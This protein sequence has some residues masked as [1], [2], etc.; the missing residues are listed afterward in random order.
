VRIEGRQAPRLVIVG[1][2]GW[3]NENVLDLLERCAPLQDSVIEVSGLS[4]PAL[5]RLL[6]NARGLLMPSF[7]EGYGLPVAEALAA[8]VPVLASELPVFREIGGSGIEFIDPLAGLAWLKAIRDRTQQYR[9]WPLQ[10]SS[11]PTVKQFLAT[12]D[13]F[14]ENI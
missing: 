5:K 7:A 9:Q 13:D 11:P 6:D 8:G 10:R 1:K 14:V 2:R 12:I 3:G 4:T